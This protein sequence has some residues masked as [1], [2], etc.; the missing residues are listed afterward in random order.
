MLTCYISDPS[1]EGGTFTVNVFSKSEETLNAFQEDC[2]IRLQN[3]NL[4]K[5]NGNPQMTINIFSTVTVYQPKTQ[6]R[7]KIEG[8]KYST[9]TLD[10]NVI[11]AL[12]AWNSEFKEAHVPIRVPSK[13]P[14]LET[15]EL[16]DN[17]A[18]YFD[19]VGQIVNIAYTDLNVILTLTDFTEN[20]N[21]PSTLLK[22]KIVNEKYLINCSIWDEHI[23]ECENLQIGNYVSLRN[24]VK[25]CEN[26][27]EFNIHGRPEEK[28][29]HI[30]KL[31]P[32]DSLLKKLIERRDKYQITLKKR[33]RNDCEAYPLRTGMNELALF[34][35]LLIL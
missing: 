31:K 34:L 8:T 13:R 9:T 6:E 11:K 16:Y 32:D 2:I 4:K 3:F 27:L 35:I 14:L 5:F 10:M 30:Y 33:S 18:K 21:P 7:I 1:I 17:P 23:L 19:Y 29:R 12:D 15:A 26:D 24:C 22:Q 20:P 25:K 28:K